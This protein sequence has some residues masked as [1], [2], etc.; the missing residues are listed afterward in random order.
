LLTDVPIEEVM[1]HLSE[2]GVELVDSP[3]QRIGAIAPLR[4]V[5]FFDPDENLVE[6]SDQ[7]AAEAT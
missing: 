5:Y 2:H 4:S 6:I 1:A 3:V 7:L